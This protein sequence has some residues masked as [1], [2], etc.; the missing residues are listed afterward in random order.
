MQDP[1]YVKAAF[2][3]IAPRYVLTNH[4]LSL[5]IDVLWRR[6]VARLVG[7]TGAKSILDVATGSGDLAVTVQQRCPGTRVVGTDFCAP[8][9]E[10]ARKRGLEELLVA[11][12]MD[13]PFEDGEFDAV[14][15]GFG[16]RN[17]ASWEGA[18]K[19]M[20]RV[21]KP[22]GHL[23][24]LDFSLPGNALVRAGYRFYLHRVMPAVGGLLTGKRDAYEYLGG[25]IESFPSGEAMCALLDGAGF[26]GTR[27]EPLSFGIS[28][29]Y[30]ARRS[31]EG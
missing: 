15:V 1:V 23:I 29:I 12:A 3:G 2:E 6:R 13:L 10:H 30:V 8:M 28:S 31:G 19:E 25:T 7:E 14:T 11:D 9:L 22:G 27:S 24:V 4:V 21:I 18:A 16:L 17:M 20:G 26:E 5:G